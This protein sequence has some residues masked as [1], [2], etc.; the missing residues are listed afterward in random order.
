[1][2][3][4]ARGVLQEAPV[5]EKLC[6]ENVRGKLFVGN[7]AGLC[8]ANYKVD[9]AALRACVVAQDNEIALRDVK[10]S[11]L[12]DRVNG[13]TS[14]LNAYELLRNRLINAFKRDKLGNATN[15]DRR[16]LAEGNG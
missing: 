5:T 6:V 2:Q 14:S 12:E 10:I 3:Q 15:A 16:A 7:P 9:Q 1:M 13:P 11:S 8:Y 4:D